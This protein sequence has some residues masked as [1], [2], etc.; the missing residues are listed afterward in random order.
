M[1]KLF[2]VHRFEQGA[3][4]HHLH[5]VLRQPHQLHGQ[6]RGGRHDGEHQERQSISQTVRHKTRT[7]SSKNL[8]HI[9]L[10]FVVSQLVNLISY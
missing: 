1:L 8:F 3:R 6:V 2:Q 9:G 7:P 4:R 5:P 10:L